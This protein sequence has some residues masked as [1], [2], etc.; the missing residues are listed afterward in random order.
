MKIVFSG[1]KKMVDGRPEVRFRNFLKHWLETTKKADSLR[2][3]GSKRNFELLSLSFAISIPAHD[4]SGK[5]PHSKMASPR[6]I[7][8]GH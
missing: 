1:A 4:D 2:S 8:Q 5:F 7:F 3:I 6:L